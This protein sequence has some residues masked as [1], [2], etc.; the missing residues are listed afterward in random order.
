MRRKLS[1]SAWMFLPK[2]PKRARYSSTASMLQPACWKKRSASGG[3]SR[4]VSDTST[5]QARY[6]RREIHRRAPDLR[7]SQPA[8]PMWSGC[9]CVTT[10]RLS[11]PSKGGAACSCCQAA[12]VSSVRTPV[13]TRVQP[14]P[15]SRPHTLMWF[16]RKG[17]GSRIQ[18][19]PGATVVNRPGSG[20]ACGYCS[21]S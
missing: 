12:V 16:R 21:D 1:G 7:D 13:S 4:L 17:I 15:S 6:S 5:R 3:A 10:M 14:S 20:T 2:F 18:C 9:M 11:G 19:T 8:M